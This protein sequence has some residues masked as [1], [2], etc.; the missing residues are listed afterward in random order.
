MHFRS[1]QTRVFVLFVGLL[2]PVMAIVYLA[3]NTV[4]IGNARDVI[5]N[6]LSVTASVFRS[7]IESRNQRLVEAARLLSSDHAIK[8]AYAPATRDH[9]TLLS[10]LDNHRRRI[11][12]ADVLVLVTLEG[13]V[14]ANTLHPETRGRDSPFPRLLEAAG[15]NEDWQAAA[16]TMVD[17][18][19]YQVVAVPL[20]IP[21]P[22]AWVCIGFLVDDVLARELKDDTLS[23]VSILSADHDQ[24]WK[25]AASALPSRLGQVLSDQMMQQPWQPGRSASFQMRGEAYVTLVLPLAEDNGVRIVAVLQRSLQEALRPYQR[26]QIIITVL[27]AAALVLAIVIA[28]TFSRRVTRPVLRLAKGAHMIEQGDYNQCVPVEQHD[29]IGELASAFNTMAKGLAERDQVRGLLGKVVSPAIAE[30]LLSTS[31]ELG[32]EECEVTVLFSDVRNFTTLCEDREPQEILSLLNMYLT[33]ASAVVEQNG[34]VVDKYIGDAMMALF[35]AP[36]RHEDDA[37]RAVRTAV[38][39]CNVLEELNGLFAR[40]GLPEIGIGVGIN[41]AVVVAGNMGSRTRMNYTVIG[42]GVNLAS[43]LE[44]LTKKYGVPVIVSEAT[45]RAAREFEYLELD[46]VRVKGKHEPVTIYQP[47]GPAGATE[48]RVRDELGYY[49]DALCAYRAREWVAARTRFAALQKQFSQR[50]LYELY[51]QRI[52]AFL[53]HPPGDDWDG[54]V[55][56]S[57]K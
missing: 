43:R 48:P 37:T 4:N 17:G 54:T 10:A 51:L 29:E 6:N 14:I 35:G 34:G 31:I 55:T 22:D 46:R 41:T 33:E 16:I 27:F 9:D 47:L 57:E 25:L 12:D 21:E 7:R 53:H 44:G 40:Q 45:R 8:Q 18:R 19:I 3:V 32:G 39:M 2:L 5:E 50:K 26:L 15:K 36:L 52:E 38:Q 11:S 13:T 56:F 49:S 1:F 24:S 42:D 30:K 23:Y 28:R 20:L